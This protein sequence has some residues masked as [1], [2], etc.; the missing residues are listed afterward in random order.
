MP[1]PSR[2]AVQGSGTP[3]RRSR[4]IDAARNQIAIVRVWIVDRP[5]CSSGAAA[6]TEARAL[7]L[8]SSS[9]SSMR[10][11][12]AEQQFNWRATRL[13][14]RRRWLQGRAALPMPP[15]ET[16][17]QWFGNRRSARPRFL[18][19]A[20]TAGGAHACRPQRPVDTPRGASAAAAPCP[21]EQ[22]PGASQ[23][24]ARRGRP[25]GGPSGRTGLGSL[26]RT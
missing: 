18:V 3:T 26:S 16:A 7:P 13:A 8:A 21:P 14:D 25:V 23:A 19:G 17:G 11:V 24:S 5:P 20:L 1:P 22:C 15:P 12:L 6:L 2:R 9:N 10:T 4:N